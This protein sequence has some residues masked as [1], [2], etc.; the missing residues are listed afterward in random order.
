MNFEYKQL[1]P[2]NFSPSSRV[3]IYQSNRLFTLSEAMELEEMIGAFCAQWTTHGAKVSA[4]GN[5]FFGRFIV[6]M[7]DETA[8][9]VS[10]CSTDSSVRLIKDIAANYNVDLFNRMQL[11]F[12]IKDGIEILPLAQV[13]YALENGFI[14]RETL[15]F[16]NLVQT[17][18]ELENNWIIPVGTS[19]LMKKMAAGV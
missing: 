1:L 18:E 2:E 10:G 11:A 15:F 3:W 17:K 5:L 6:L 13:N 12:I 14:S 19:W 16:N 8:A 7:A 4:Y 9:A